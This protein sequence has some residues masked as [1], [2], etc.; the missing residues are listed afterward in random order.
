MNELN[1]SELKKKYLRRARHLEQARSASDTKIQRSARVH[2]SSPDCTVKV[3]RK[4]KRPSAHKNNVREHAEKA[5]AQLDIQLEVNKELKR[6]LIASVGSDLQV[7]LEQLADEKVKASQ[8][9]NS[10][11]RQMRETTEEVDEMAIEC[12]IWRSKFVASRVMIDELA[13]WKAALSVHLRDSCKALQYLLKEREDLYQK[14]AVSNVTLQGVLQHLES[15][16]ESPETIQDH[17][18]QEGKAATVFPIQHSEKSRFPALNL[19][20]ATVLELAAVNLSLAESIAQQQGARDRITL[21]QISCT[22]EPTTGEKLARQVLQN[23]QTDEVADLPF[24]KLKFS[25][26]ELFQIATRALRGV[27]GSLSVIGA[28][29][30]IGTFIVYKSIRTIPRFML[31]NLAV[32]DLVTAISFFPDINEDTLSIPLYMFI[33]FMLLKP[34]NKVT[35]VIVFVFCWIAPLTV[36]LWL[37]LSRHLGRSMDLT[38][39]CFIT[40]L[41]ATS[42]DPNG[43]GDG[44]NAGNGT[45][46]DTGTLAFSWQ[47]QSPFIMGY[48]LW[49]YLSFFLL[50]ALY[51]ALKCRIW[52]LKVK[53]M[54][55]TGVLR[56][57][58]VTQEIDQK[59]ILLPLI[60][61]LLRI[62]SC[63][64]ILYSSLCAQQSLQLPFQLTVLLVL[65][66]EPLQGFVNGMVF[67]VFTRSIQKKLISSMSFARQ[68][69]DGHIDN[70]ESTT[71]VNS[72]RPFITGSL[73]HN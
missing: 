13:S 51:I 16:N 64:F 72:D 22:A 30:I 24:N 12:D 20:R 49:N 26:D 14:M 29:L 46:C 71:S 10:V 45:K 48:L 28:T 54:E 69:L 36:T 60:Y 21:G 5:S 3:S 56:L 17:V 40:I 7:K 44:H 52:R 4:H 34:Y 31:V 39:S 23:K 63:I 53:L 32:A 41:N 19:G 59:L 57:P 61:F 35:V 2:D 73:K 15:H 18:R 27:A 62:G 25:E 50:P 65:F 43:D 37:G 58:M 66:L 8:K 42:S 6:L 68:D 9:L 33:A 47:H 1:E 55:T 67:V 11:V 38:Q 70:F